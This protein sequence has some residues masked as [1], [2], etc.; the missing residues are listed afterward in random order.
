MTPEPVSPVR[1]IG[2]VAPVFRRLTTALIAFPAALLLVTLAVNNREPV[3]FNLD[4]L[5]IL[6]LAPVALPLYVYLLVAL[7]A[8]VLLGGFTVWM[9]QSRYRRSARAGSAEATRWRTEA[10]RLSRERDAAVP[11]SSRAL[12]AGNARNA[13]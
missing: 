13:A 1:T 8:G 2:D 4:P 3:A 9:S 11:S 5:N 10:D 6:G 12:T 7:I